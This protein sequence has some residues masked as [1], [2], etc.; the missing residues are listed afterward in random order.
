MLLLWR[1][2][3]CRLLFLVI[4]PGSTFGNTFSGLIYNPKRSILKLIVK[5]PKITGRN[6]QVFNFCSSRLVRPFLDYHPLREINDPSYTARYGLSSF[7]DVLL[8]GFGIE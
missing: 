6:E 7:I 8:Q 4:T 5:H 1:F 2:G 3:E